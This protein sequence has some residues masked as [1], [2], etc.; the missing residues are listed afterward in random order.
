MFI[1]QAPDGRGLNKSAWEKHKDDSDWTVKE[2]R[3]DKIWVR[4]HWIGRYKKDLPSEYRHSHGITVYNRVKVKGSEWAEEGTTVDKGWIID[5]TGTQ[6]ART[7]SAA[8]T[9]YE[10]MLLS[11][12]GA[13]LEEDEDGDLVLVETGNQLKPVVL[14]SKLIM[15]EEQVAAAAEKGVDLGGWS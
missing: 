2:F 6:T 8:I 1:Y 12:A 9:L 3:N 7:K 11:Y 10:D 13:S 14:G 15:D 4:L 5:P